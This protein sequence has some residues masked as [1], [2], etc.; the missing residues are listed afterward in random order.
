MHF[1]IGIPLC[2]ACAQATESGDDEAESG[3]GPTSGR[4]TGGRAPVSGQASGGQHS[5]NTGDMWSGGSSLAGHHTGGRATPTGGS[6]N[7]NSG[8]G[9]NNT[10][11]SGG[12]TDAYDGG[13]AD[14]PNLPHSS[15]HSGDTAVFT[16]DF[17]QAAC[18]AEMVGELS[19]WE[20]VSLHANNCHTQ[21]PTGGTS[22]KFLGLCAELGMGGAGGAAP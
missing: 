16:C 7:G 9:A 11:T 13:C 6:E 3:S 18:T 5:D 12:G 19:L 21:S 20:C 10:G 1:L 15:V 14:R 2:V 8:T 4:S 17:V 22:W